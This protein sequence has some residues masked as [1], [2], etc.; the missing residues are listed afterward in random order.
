M[1]GINVFPTQI[2]EQICKVKGLAA[3]YQIEL[4][5]DGRLDKM[6]VLAE[7]NNGG[8][9]PQVRARLGREAARRIK[10]VIGLSAEVVVGAPGSVERSQGKARRV[11]DNRKG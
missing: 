11:V 2:E 10:D 8:V 3:H 1:R 4:G 5:R 6:T 9:D 7:A